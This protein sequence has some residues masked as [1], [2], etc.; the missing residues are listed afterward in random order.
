M[1]R[2][3]VQGAQGQ[4]QDEKASRSP[5]VS[6]I[7]VE[8]GAKAEPS[9]QSTAHAAPLSNS[10]TIDAATMDT[11]DKVSLC[12]E[13]LSV[14]IHDSPGR[15]AK[16][17][18]KEHDSQPK[19][20]LNH[21]SLRAESGALTAILGGSGSGKTT[22]L[23]QLSGRTGQGRLITS[24][25]VLFNGIEDSSGVKAAYVIQED[26]L[27][28]TL[29]IRETLTYAAKL[30]LPASVSDA[31]KQQKVEEIMKE[32]GLSE[33]ADTK[34]GNHRHRGCSGGEKRRTSIGVQLLSNPS[35]LYLD[36]PTTGLDST[37]AFQ[38]V[39]T[40]QGLARKGRTVIVTSRFHDCYFWRDGN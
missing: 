18:R 16:L 34:I 9:V 30:R 5:D 39:K 14:H 7:P 38:V 17:L 33:V 19:A 32:L 28:P 4:S 31:E 36:E 26:I 2:N 29:T 13:H 21:I 8:N 20:I 15:L 24:G 3:N 27:Q 1:E 22:L 23:N 10:F 35:I 25:K 40:L 37:N 12:V 11:A 6:T